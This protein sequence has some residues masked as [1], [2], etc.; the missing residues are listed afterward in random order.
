MQLRS[1][2]PSDVQLAQLAVQIR[3]PKYAMTGLEAQM[4]RSLWFLN[5]IRFQILPIAHRSTTPSLATPTEEIHDSACRT[6]AS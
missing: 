3:D 1:T 5:G 2:Q 4:L 6:R